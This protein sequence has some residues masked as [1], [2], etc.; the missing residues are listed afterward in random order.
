V[1]LASAACLLSDRVQMSCSATSSRTA[2]RTRSS[3]TFRAAQWVDCGMYFA[4]VA[5]RALNAHWVHSHAGGLSVLS[6]ET[7]HRDPDDADAGAAWTVQVIC[8]RGRLS[9]VHARVAGSRIIAVIAC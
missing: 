1:L 9:P 6:A 4:D 3:R 8:R 7:V 2:S 5:L